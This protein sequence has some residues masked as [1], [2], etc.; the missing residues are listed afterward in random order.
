MFHG[1]LNC[2]FW[3]KVGSLGFGSIVQ[4]F[5]FLS[6]GSWF[7]WVLPTFV[8]FRCFY[9][10]VV[11]I[12]LIQQRTF[13]AG[14]FALVLPEFQ[15][16]YLVYF[17]LRSR[18]LNVCI[19]RMLRHS[20]QI[21]CLI[22]RRSTYNHIRP[23]HHPRILTHN[24]IKIR[25]SIVLGRRISSL[26]C[27]W[28]SLSIVVIHI[29]MWTLNH[30]ISEICR[31]QSTLLNCFLNMIILLNWKLLLIANIINFKFAFPAIWCLLWPE[32]RPTWAIV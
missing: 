18:E 12:F 28:P 16:T 25:F 26:M 15:L 24:R 20:E 8:S 29:S 3:S 2:W 32:M 9:K 6:G 7:N 30:R 4:S 31:F 21:G 14:I 10:V 13:A 5:Y 27:T 11:A 23:F 1:S 22:Q 17:I 19:Y